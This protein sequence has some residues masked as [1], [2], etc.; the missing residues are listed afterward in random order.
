MRHRLVWLLVC[1]AAVAAGAGVALAAAG[2]ST[3]PAI[4]CPLEP[5]STVP[6]CCGPPV[7]T[8]PAAR[9]AAIPCC[10]CC[11]PVT[12]ASRSAAIA[13]L[14]L[15]ISSSPDP[16]TA[17]HTVTISGRRAG[18]GSGALVVLWEK[19]PAAKGFKDVAHTT[20]GSSGQYQFVRTGVETNRKWYVAS[21][22]L[23]SVTLDQQ[24]KAVVT[25]TRD[26]DVHVSPNHA[27][28][29]LLL[30]RRTAHGW[31]VMDREAIPGTV[32][33]RDSITSCGQAGFFAISRPIELRAVFPGDARNIRSV[34]NI[35][36]L[37]TH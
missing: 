8:A 18:A 25:L 32:R 11:G 20:T 9:P 4:I 19:L 15:T 12:V 30:E 3:A 6:T 34:S 23:R 24:V 10:V 17:G 28:E 33:H 22:G 14:P 35:V 2:P 36:V 27:C 13:C 16:S 1:F 31:V 5:N 37:G 7:V 26:L 29:R 21:G